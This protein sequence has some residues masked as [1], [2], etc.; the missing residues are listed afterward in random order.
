MGGVTICAWSYVPAFLTVELASSVASPK[1]MGK[2]L[3]LSGTLTIVMFLTIGIFVVSRW[4]YD[5]GEIIGLTPVWPSQKPTNVLT[6]LFNTFQ[7]LGNLVSYMLDSVPLGRFCQTVLAPTF[8]D[9]WSPGDI[10]R[11]LGYTL[12][13]FMCAFAVAVLV[14][15]VNILL[16]FTTAFTVPWVTQIYPA[17]LYWR[18]IRRRR[19]STQSETVEATASG[20]DQVPSSG[21]FPFESLCVLLVFV[22]GCASFVC[23]FLSAVGKVTI[24]ELRPP[25]QIGCGSWLIWKSN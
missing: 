24:A 21:K 19:R 2:S 20:S 6:S 23:C 8:G 5:V 14:P 18:F 12:P 4:G 1:N 16:D 3:A 17:V 25:L 22:V 11:Y 9:T 10:M 13:T 7:L 15:S